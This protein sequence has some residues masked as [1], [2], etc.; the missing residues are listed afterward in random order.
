MLKELGII[1]LIIGIL[2]L[3]I[4]GLYLIQYDINQNILYI[5]LGFGIVFIIISMILL[6]VNYKKK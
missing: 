2:I 1:F 5:F 6:L 3:I 4:L